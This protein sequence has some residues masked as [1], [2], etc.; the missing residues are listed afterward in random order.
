MKEHKVHPEGRQPKIVVVGGGTG[1]STMLRGLKEH[2]E[3]ITAVVSVAD[4][5]GGSGVLRREMHMLPPGD[6]RNCIL[7]LSKTEPVMEKL[8]RYRFQSGSL[9]GQNFGNLFLAA[10]NKI[11]DGDFV[12]AV[13][14]VSSVLRVRGKVLPVTATDVE[15]VARMENGQRIVGES[16][17]GNAVNQCGCRIKQVSLAAKHKDEKICVVPE[18]VEELQQADLIVLGPGS[19]YTSILPNLV[20]PGFA[21]SVKASKAPVVY[22]NNIMTQPGETDGY[23]AFDHV[24]AILSHTSPDFIDYCIVNSQKVDTPLLCRYIEQDSEVVSLDEQRFRDAG[25]RIFPRDLVGIVDN[26]YI[27]HDTG[28]LADAILDVLNYV[29]RTQEVSDEGVLLYRPKHNQP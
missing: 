25:I 1:L 10:M 19:L 14:N 4:D 13:K 18:V 15:L 9:S 17:I 21:E 28:V 3:D 20:V 22:I 24:E 11:F 23:T 16:E 6:I 12:T 8:L 2:T 5:G 29:T 26:R 27:R 7:A